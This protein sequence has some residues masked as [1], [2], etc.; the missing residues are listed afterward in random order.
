MIKLHRRD[1]AAPD[2]VGYWEAWQSEP[3]VLTLHRGQVGE[4]GLTAAVHV[5]FWKSPQKALSAEAAEARAEGFV[6]L[7]PEDHVE[8]FVQFGMG[9]DPEADLHLIGGV[10]NLCDEVL[11]WTGNGRAGG[12][13]IGAD[14]MTVFVETV[15]PDV[16]VRS[17]VDALS[18]AE[19]TEFVVAVR[20]GDDE[21]RVVWP[22]DHE[23]PFSF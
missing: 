15:Q 16:A 21:Y 23:Q 6:E 19:H 18:Q 2:V 17:L 14:T 12:H 1:P 20:E 22:E 13:D 5:P 3:R 8:V 11:G 7:A 4:I 10:E 9:E